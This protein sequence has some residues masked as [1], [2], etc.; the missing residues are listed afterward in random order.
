[1]SSA[2][3]AI[4]GEQ[5]FGFTRKLRQTLITN[6]SRI[7]AWVEEQKAEA[8]AAFAVQEAEM[9]DRQ[10]RLD[11]GVAEF[12]AAQLEDG[13]HVAPGASQSLAEEKEQE[14]LELEKLREAARA[15]TQR[16]EGTSSACPVACCLQ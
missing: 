1:M 10:A 14:E 2:S 16:M 8:D 3:V 7:N 9:A 12:L 13:L 4:N 6:Q 11:Q 5:P 15:S